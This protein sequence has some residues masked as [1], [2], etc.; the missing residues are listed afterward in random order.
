MDEQTVF[1]EMW[2]GRRFQDKSE[3]VRKERQLK[4][5]TKVQHGRSNQGLVQINCLKTSALLKATYGWR[6][7]WQRKK[8]K[9]A[10]RPPCVAHKKIEKA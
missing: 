10:K 4:P 5:G 8:D 1:V 2:G 7:S 6:T 3:K 9:I